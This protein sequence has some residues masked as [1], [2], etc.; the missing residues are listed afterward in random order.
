MPTAAAIKGV[1]KI[2]CSRCN[3]QRYSMM[4]HN[5]VSFQRLSTFDEYLT[6]VCF[7]NKSVAPQCVKCRVSTALSSALGNNRLRFVLGGCVA[8]A[9][10]GTR[11]NKTIKTPW[12]PWF[13]GE[14]HRGGSVMSWRYWFPQQ[15]S[16]RLAGTIKD[17]FLKD[18]GGA[19][20]YQFTQCQTTDII[21]SNL[22]RHPPPPPPPCI[23]SFLDA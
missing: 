9:I 4:H 22:E 12:T 21:L 14:F 19:A 13:Y 17:F 18:N 20:S 15:S 6:D 23:L 10:W 2:Y 11:P 16:S 1:H 5:D 3:N 7:W 8:D